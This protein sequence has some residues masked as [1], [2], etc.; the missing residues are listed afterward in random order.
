MSN[1]HPVLKDEIVSYGSPRSLKVLPAY[2]SAKDESAL[3]DKRVAIK[4]KITW[5]EIVA[6]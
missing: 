5:A 2:G 6:R 3:V 1:N 4:R